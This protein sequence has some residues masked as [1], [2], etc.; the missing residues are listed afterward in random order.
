M[1]HFINKHLYTL[2]MKNVCKSLIGNCKW[3]IHSTLVI[4]NVENEYQTCRTYLI[5]ISVY[6]FY[7]F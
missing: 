1:E 6:E 4:I 2:S 5:K 3:M 7:I